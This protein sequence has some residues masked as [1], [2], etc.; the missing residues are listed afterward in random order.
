MLAEVVIRG[1]I[2]GSTITSAPY[3]YP[4]TVCNDCVVSNLGACPLP[5]GVDVRTGNGCNPFQ[6][7]VVDCCT[8][9]DNRLVCPAATASM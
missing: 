8:D 3:L 5:S 1:D 6:D 7:G 9:A 4:I 2:N